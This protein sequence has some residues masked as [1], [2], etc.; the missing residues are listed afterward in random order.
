[1]RRWS[2]EVRLLKEEFCQV[3]ILLEFEADQWVEWAKAV[4][5]GT[6]SMDEASTQGM[7]TYALKQEAMYRDISAHAREAESISKIARRKRRLRVPILDPL[8]QQLGME[9]R[10][11][12][13]DDNM[14]LRE[15]DNS[16]I[17]VNRGVMER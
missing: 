4:P 9:D 11:D 14:G 1:V 6:G 5:V 3:P 8:V 15:E 16:D 17:D 13:N 10:E 12:D 2:E 7:I